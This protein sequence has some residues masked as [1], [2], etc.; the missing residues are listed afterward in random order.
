MV[1]LFSLI[2]RSPRILNPN[3]NR[4]LW[5]MPSVHTVILLLQLEIHIFDRFATHGLYALGCL[6]LV[7][8]PLGVSPTYSKF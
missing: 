3:P 2:L 1:I 4:Q 8:F 5:Y 7:I 6:V